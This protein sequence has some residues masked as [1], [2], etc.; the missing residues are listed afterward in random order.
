MLD[1]CST[2][3]VFM[4]TYMCARVCIHMYICIRTCIYMY[5]QYMYVQYTV[6]TEQVQ[7][8]FIRMH[9]CKYSVST[10]HERACLYV[11]R[12]LKSCM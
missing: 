1:M 7:F 11:Q 12:I 10:V 2:F 3:Y 6:R 5:V 9:N 8:V 4:Y